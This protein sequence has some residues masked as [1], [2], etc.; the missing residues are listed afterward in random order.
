VVLVAS[1]GK[2]F[3]VLNDVMLFVGSRRIVVEDKANNIPAFQ[4]ERSKY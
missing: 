2:R 1:D 4:M 3:K